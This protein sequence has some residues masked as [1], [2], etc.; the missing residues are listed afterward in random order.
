MSVIDF[1]MKDKE[2]IRSF[3]LLASYNG[4]MQDI[5]NILKTLFRAYD[6]D[7]VSPVAQYNSILR[8]RDWEK[9]SGMKVDEFGGIFWSWLVLQ[10]GEYGTSPRFGWIYAENAR[11]LYSILGEC[12]AELIEDG[13]EDG[14]C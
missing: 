8:P 4:Y 7:P 10:Y 9:C 5:K 13:M 6:F 3:V 11:R 12:L 1:T 2:A 14:S